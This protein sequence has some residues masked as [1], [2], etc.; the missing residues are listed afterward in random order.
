MEILRTIQAY[1]ESGGMRFLVIG[2]HALKTYQ[3]HRHLKDYS[4]LL[5]LLRTKHVVFSEAEFKALCIKHATVQL[6]EKV[7]SELQLW[8]KISS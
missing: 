5:G 1:A 2:G 8:K 7:S 3:E 4:D 6:F